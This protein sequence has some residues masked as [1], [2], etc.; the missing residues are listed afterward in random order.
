MG[1]AVRSTGTGDESWT[2]MQGTAPSSSGITWADDDEETEGDA[3]GLWLMG[4]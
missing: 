2:M 4:L 3:D 1:K